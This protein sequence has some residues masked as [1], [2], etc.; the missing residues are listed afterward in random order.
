MQYIKKHVFTGNL[1]MQIRARNHF[2]S[3]TNWQR[4]QKKE[5]IYPYPG[6]EVGYLIL[7][8][9]EYELVKSFWKTIW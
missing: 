5:R 4:S 1:K 2:S 3:L 8:Y 6:K 9:W 7:C